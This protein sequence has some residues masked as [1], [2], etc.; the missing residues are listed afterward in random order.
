M[1]RCNGGF[2]STCCAAIQAQLAPWALENDRRQV[3]SEA[4]SGGVRREPP[5]RRSPWQKT[6]SLART[7]SFPAPSHQVHVPC[8]RYPDR[9]AT[10]RARARTPSPAPH[11]RLD[12]RRARMETCPTRTGRHTDRRSLQRRSENALRVRTASAGGRTARHP[13]IRRCRYCVRLNPSSSRTTS[14]R[15]ST[16]VR[17]HADFGS[18]FPVR[19]I[20]F[21]NMYASPG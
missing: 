6:A 17:A 5:L 19:S 9:R 20:M 13:R 21:P 12:C 14:N 7:V 1:P 10:P 2:T 4:P 15:R 8:R 16:A 11:D 18:T 3:Q